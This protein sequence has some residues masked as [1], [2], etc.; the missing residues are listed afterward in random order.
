MTRLITLA[1]LVL[2]AL[3]QASAQRI[4]A[5]DKDGQPI[6][7]VSIILPLTAPT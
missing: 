5:I 3:L 6:P 2:A 4:R 1:V 7:F